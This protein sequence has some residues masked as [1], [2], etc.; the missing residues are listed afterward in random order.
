MK[1]GML[2]KRRDGERIGDPNMN[3]TCKVRDFVTNGDGS[4]KI[5]NKYVFFPDDIVE[6]DKNSF[7]SISTISSGKKTYLLFIL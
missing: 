6:I 1:K 7:L 2:F 4:Y 3:F 5:N